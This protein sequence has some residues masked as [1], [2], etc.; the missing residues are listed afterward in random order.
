MKTYRNLILSLAILLSASSLVRSETSTETTTTSPVPSKKHP[1]RL[2][3]LVVKLGLNEEQ[4]GKISFILKDEQAAQKQLKKDVTV[5]EDL[6][7]SRNREISDAHEAQI[8][9]VLTVEQQATYDQIQ[10]RVRTRK[11][12]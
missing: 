9:A 10:S 6:K 11:K 2:D 12:M 1:T 7:K 5:P 4:K 3:T 8:R